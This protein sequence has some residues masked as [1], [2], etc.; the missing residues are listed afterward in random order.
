MSK[1]NV[2]LVLAEDNSHT[3]ILRKITEASTVLE[4]GPA[5]GVMSNYLSKNLRCKI[6]AVEY[7]SDAAKNVEKF[8]EKVVVGNIEDYIWEQEFAEIKF[9]HIIFADVLEHLYNPW[10]VLKRVKPFLKTNGTILISLPNIAHNAIIMNLLE[11]KF[12]YQTTGL[13]DNTHIRFFTKHSIDKMIYDCEYN[14]KSVEAISKYPEN[15]EFKKLYQDFNIGVVSSL[16]TKEYGHIYQFIYEISKN[17]IDLQ[18]NDL[19]FNEEIDYVEIFYDTGCGY[20]NIECLKSYGNTNGMV[21]FP[22]ETKIHAIR[23]DPANIPG[24]IIPKDIVIKMEDSGGKSYDCQVLSWIGFQEQENGMMICYGTDPQIL[25][26]IPVNNPVK[27]FFHIPYHK[28]YKTAD[29]FEVSIKSNNNS[30]CEL[31][32]QDINEGIQSDLIILQDTDNNAK[33]FKSNLIPLLIENKLLS[34]ESRIMDME[35]QLNE[36]NDKLNKQSSFIKQLHGRKGISFIL[37]IFGINLN[38]FID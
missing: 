7:D 29:K 5:H 34:R 14:V 27:L 1:Y 4:F 2:P 18:Y 16:L 20:N 25:L 8:C 9:D 37:K 33:K 19:R 21:E 38:G 31:V 22:A 13:L 32:I 26:S 36:M 10:L 6:Y 35:K 3:K 15:T 23:L 17:A 24:I 11:N 28:F 30:S 12:E